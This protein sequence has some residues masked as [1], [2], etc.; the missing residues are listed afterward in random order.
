M[1]GILPAL[2]T[3]DSFTIPNPQHNPNSGNRARSN[4]LSSSAQI[5]PRAG[6]NSLIAYWSC[7]F[8]CSPT[9]RKALLQAAFSPPTG[10]TER[11]TC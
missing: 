4:G 6:A 10:A 1:S 11:T 9:A 2:E 3:L 7:N 8:P 5:P